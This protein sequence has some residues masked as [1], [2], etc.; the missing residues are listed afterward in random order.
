M[1]MQMATKIFFEIRE[2][3]GQIKTPKFHNIDLERWQDKYSE[4]TALKPS[5][6]QIATGLVG[7][8]LNNLS[9]NAAQTSESSVCS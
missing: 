4:L 3:Y 6:I 2:E 8:C 1:N 5:L 7:S 9:T